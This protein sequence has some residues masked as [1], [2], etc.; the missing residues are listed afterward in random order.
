MRTEVCV[1]KIEGHSVYVVSVG[2]CVK[3]E[4]RIRAYFDNYNDAWQWGVDR[5]EER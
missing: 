3:G 5:N 4:L 1:S 2:H